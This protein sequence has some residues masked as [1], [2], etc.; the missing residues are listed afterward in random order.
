MALVDRISRVISDDTKRS[1]HLM[2]GRRFLIQ[3]ERYVSMD[4]EVSA[5]DTS[6]NAS[7]IVPL[8][9]TIDWLPPGKVK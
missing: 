1:N 2:A 6:G 7:E 4:L 3:D 5:I 9:V 8:N